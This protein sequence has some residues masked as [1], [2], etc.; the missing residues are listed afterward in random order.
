M[1][2]LISAFNLILYQ[3]LFNALVLLYLYLPGHDFG[4]AI[5]VLTILIRLLLYP[6]GIQA[7]RSQRVLQELQPK[8]KEIQE[9]YKREP[10]KQGRAMMELYQKEKINPFS[11][12]LPSLI[13]L[14]ILI[15]LYRVF[16][17]GFQPE[18][19]INL[20]S[21][22]PQPGE[23]NPTFF[24]MINLS[25]P[26]FVLAILAGISQFVQTKMLTPRQQV[27]GGQ[28]TKGKE[29]ISQFSGMFQK[30][31]LYFF[32]IFT[33][34]ILLKLPSAIGLYWFVTTLFSIIQQYYVQP[35]Y[36]QRN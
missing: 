27:G 7:I 35:K 24:G 6:L 10:E 22:V 29:R 25:Q 28:I 18:Q 2:L 11:G 26:S 12:C 9:R 19:M 15:A 1:N 23:I 4:L 21:F 20:Y 13:Q 36:S 34:F 30:Q 16:W 17:N 33:V 14:P 32:P 8:I 5:I 31:M 3:P